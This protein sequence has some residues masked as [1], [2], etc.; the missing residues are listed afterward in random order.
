MMIQAS[1]MPWQNNYVN[2]T[3][4]HW[5]LRVGHSSVD[6]PLEGTPR[7]LEYIYANKV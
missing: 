7:L 1:E 5:Q 2:L 6:V 4:R 3:V